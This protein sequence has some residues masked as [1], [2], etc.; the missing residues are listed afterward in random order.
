MTSLFQDLRYGARMLAKRPGFT[1]VAVLTLAL[2]IGA[3]TAIF[4]VVNGVLLKSLSFPEAD[5]L[6]VLSQSSKENPFIAVSY[7]DYLDWRDRQTVFED[8]AAG[9]PA[10]GVLTGDGE[11]ERIIGRSVT[12]SFFPTLGV[13][14]QVGRFFN[15]TE[16]QVGAEPVIVLSYGLWQ[17]RFGGDSAVIDKTIQYNGHGWRVV[18]VL[19]ADFDFYG[20][21]NLNNGFFTPLGRQADQGYMR[22]RRERGAWVMARLKPGVTH[23][24][25]QAELQRLATE[26]AEQYPYANTGI[27]IVMK[28]F[29]EDYVGEVRPAL[30]ILSVAVGLLLLIACANVANLMLARAASRQKEIAVR[31]ALGASR[32]QIVR[33]LLTES[34]LL[35]VAGGTLGVLLAVWG[36]DLLIQLNPDALPRTEE[37]AIDPRVL[38]FTA[39]VAFM[40]ALLFGLA[41]AMQTTKANLQEALKEGGRQAESGAGR[42]RLRSALVVGEV[43]LSLILLVGAG[44]LVKS[45]RQVMQVDAGFEARNVLTM[46]IRLNDGKYREASQSITFLQDLMER[47]RILPGVT[48]VGVTTGFPFGPLTGGSLIDYQIDG[49]AEPPPA[50]GRAAVVMQSV[51]ETYHQAFGIPL[52]AG[53]SFHASDTATSSPVIIIDETF[54]RRLFPDGTIRDALGK[55]LRF[56][57][58]DEPWREIVGVVKTVRQGSLEEEGR[59]RLFR[60]WLQMN[61]KWIAMQLRAMDLIIKTS[62]EPSAFVA[63]VKGEV[64]ALDKDQPIANVRTLETLLSQTIAPRRFSLALFAVFAFVAVVLGAIGLYGVMSYTVVQRT[65]EIGIRLALGAQTGDVMKMVFRQGILMTLSGIAVGLTAALL[66]TR[67]MAALLFNVSATDPVTYIL[68]AMLLTLVAM[69]SCWIPARRATKVDPITALRLTV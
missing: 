63:A 44:L 43:A 6:V 49:Q 34:G 12:A 22:D 68:I 18:G 17:R 24:Q 10:G 48:Q 62:S 52:L 40:T 2:G 33:Q 23:E 1:V 55:R 37:I 31:Q 36:V 13:Q 30:L 9:L 57:G 14:P 3:N 21:A 27:T 20:Q 7:P 51:S 4:S 54:A 28:P 8:L 69:L 50:G 29:L 11:P 67:F 47:V 32:W 39:V 25:A 26:L 66:L 58:A 38:A 16:D 61:M 60:P 35:A 19:P 41:P 56:G 65:H 42:R 64:Q 53:R 45:F 15:E 5:R 46:R 59:P